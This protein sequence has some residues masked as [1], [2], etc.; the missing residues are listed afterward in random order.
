MF[1]VDL[2]TLLDLVLPKQYCDVVVR[3][4]AAGFL[5]YIISRISPTP[6]MSLLYSTIVLYD[7]TLLLIADIYTV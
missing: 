2:K 1:R 6:S 3:K 4:I 7:N 5:G